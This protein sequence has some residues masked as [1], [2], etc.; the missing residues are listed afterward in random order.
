MCKPSLSENM[1]AEAAAKF[2]LFHDKMVAEGLSDAAIR[3]FRHSYT[4]LLNGSTGMIAEDS[5]QP[6]TNVP[7]LEADIKGQY[8]NSTALLAQTVVLKLNGGL[9]TSMGLDQ[10]KSLLSVKGDDT[11]LDLTAKQVLHM[12][13]SL[14]VDVKFVLMNSYNTSKDTLKFLQKYPQLSSDP[15]LELLQHKVPKINAASME[16]AAWPQAPHK[17]WCPP[18]HGDLYAALSGS[19][20]LNKL[21]AEG[22]KYMFVSNSDN[23]GATLDTELLAY[24][25][26]SEKPLVMEVCERTEAD[27]KG[28]H[29]AVRTCDR[30]LIFR[31]S[32]QC[33]GADAAS[34]QD[35]KRHRFFSTNNM[36][37][38]LD[39]LR[40]AI[41]AAGGLIPL[42]L[43][44]NAKTVDPQ[45]DKSPP[46]YQLETCMGHAIECFEGGGAVLVPRTRFAPV[47]K[48]SDLLLLRSDAYVV[49]DAYNVVLA[50]HIPRAPLVDLD[51]KKFKLVS[52]LDA[53]TAAGVPSLAQ[54]QRF[55][56][57]GS[58]TLSTGCVIRGSVRSRMTAWRPRR[59]RRASTAMRR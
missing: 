28:G 52:Q 18:G 33:E 12:R 20:M 39:R 47:K 46:V 58:V 10:A 42:P 44:R 49:S 29:L 26:A 8:G 37:V 34:F 27:M 56:V 38:R 55:A 31:E 54:C 23:L 19:G 53:A 43:I 51:A 6:A 16:P 2:K 25:A 32:A 11:F 45:D 15:N 40:E 48:C 57:R 5:I 3:A 21:L 17:E 30:R 41:A 24:F 7:S 4:A 13:Q 22:V 14:G 50:P 1:T 9:G 35:I 59:C 36:W